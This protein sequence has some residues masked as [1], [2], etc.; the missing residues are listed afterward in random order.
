[1][2]I[3]EA[4][5]P[6]IRGILI[7][8]GSRIKRHRETQVNKLLKNIHDKEAIHKRTLTLDTLSQL[9]ALREQLKPLTLNYAKRQILRCRTHYYDQGDKCGKSLARALRSEYTQSFV[10][11]IKG[12]GGTHRLRTEDIAAEFRSFYESLY[13]ISP[14][15]P[16]RILTNQ[17]NAI[18][19][20][21]ARSGQQR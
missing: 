16:H 20:Y 9:T 15:S 6:F 5:K 8:H 7:K 17:L 21:I 18:Q 13:N 3:W 19:D 1:M 14:H 11:L 4:H 2:T 12:K 10:P